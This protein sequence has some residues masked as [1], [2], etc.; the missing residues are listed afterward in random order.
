MQG[1]LVH[2]VDGARRDVAGGRCADPTS[3][4]L[5]GVG[6]DVDL[7]LSDLRGNR[8]RRAV[9]NGN[10]PGIAD[11]QGAAADRDGT[12]LAVRAARRGADLPIVHQGR[13]AAHVDGDNARR[14]ARTRGRG[15]GDGGEMGRCATLDAERSGVERHG[16]GIARTKSGREDLGAIGDRRRAAGRDRNLARVAARLRG[17]TRNARQC[18]RAAPIDVER[19]GLKYDIAGVAGAIRVGIDLCTARD[20]QGR[21]A[22]HRDLA[23]I[24]R[25]RGL[26]FDRAT[27]GQR[28]PRRACHHDLAAAAGCARFGRLNMPVSPVVAEPVTLSPPTSRITSPALPVA[29]VPE[30][31][32]APFASVVVPLVVT[33]TRPASPPDPAHRELAMP[34]KTGELPPSMRSEAA[35]TETLPA[36]PAESVSVLIS[37]PFR[38]LTVPPLRD[39]DLTGAAARR[40]VGAAEDSRDERRGARTAVDIERTHVERDGAGIAG[41]MGAGGDLCTICHGGRAARGHR[42]LAGVAARVARAH[43]PVNDAEVPPSRSSDPATTTI[44]PALDGEKLL[45]DT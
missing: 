32:C 23:G 45:V 4:H 27:A 40:A 21:G 19:C 42:H 8:D 3:V 11:D 39:R 31:I 26:R 17:G 22:R 1:L 34:V 28:H 35:F 41:R 5:D 38:M 10:Q 33:V 43:I 29:K 14:S 12:R 44:F 18:G 37:A 6:V 13:G 25:A 15:G 9:F 30:L 2:D 20:A 7:G 16:P 36:L 24:A